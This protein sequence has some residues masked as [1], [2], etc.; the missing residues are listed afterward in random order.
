[1][2]RDGKKR[3]LKEMRRKDEF[4][5]R[6]FFFLL[7]HYSLMAVSTIFLIYAV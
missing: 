7:I 1:M 2:R 4:R 6:G 5:G 3:L